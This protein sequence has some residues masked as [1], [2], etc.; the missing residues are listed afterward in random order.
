MLSIHCSYCIHT[1]IDIGFQE[2]SYTFSEGSGLISFNLLKFPLDR[3]SQQDF[4]FV[5]YAERSGE[6]SLILGRDVN[7]K[8]KNTVRFLSTEH[9]KRIEISVLDD[10]IPEYN[11]RFTLRLVHSSV[12]E[13]R[14][15]C[16]ESLGCHSSVTVTIE[17]NDGKFFF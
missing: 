15:L 8:S 11:E 10:L 16:Q 2:E 9:H 12:G 6:G 7:I 1:D 5:I 14:P 17:D 13:Y 4:T 3:T